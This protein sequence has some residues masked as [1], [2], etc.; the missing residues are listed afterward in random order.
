VYPCGFD[1]AIVVG[2]EEVSESDGSPGAYE[3]STEDNSDSV[4]V[5]STTK[6]T[7]IFRRPQQ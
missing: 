3:Q 6:P 2:I 5:G 1:V 7:R 4:N